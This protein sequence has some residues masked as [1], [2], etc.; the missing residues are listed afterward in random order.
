MNQQEKLI[1]NPI[2]E[3]Y[4]KNNSVKIYPHI[5]PQFN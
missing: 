2:K 5:L 1:T 3:K 4:L